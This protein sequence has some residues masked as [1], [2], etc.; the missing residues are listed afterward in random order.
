MV[1]RKV[2]NLLKIAMFINGPSTMLRYA[3]QFE[4]SEYAYLHASGT[5][6]FE[7]KGQSRM[8][9]HVFFSIQGDND[10]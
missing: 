2:E 1:S 10:M 9:L 4:L 3:L 6:K 8:S 7:L 5:S